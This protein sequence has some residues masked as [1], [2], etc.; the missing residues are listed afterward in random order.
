MEPTWT[1]QLIEARKLPDYDLRR[2]ASVSTD[3]RHRCEDCFCCAALTVLEERHP[4]LTTAKL[5]A[6]EGN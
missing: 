3:N 4:G 1:N 5:N 6:M 2:H